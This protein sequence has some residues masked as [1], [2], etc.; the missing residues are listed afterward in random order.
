[1]RNN[2]WFWIALSCLISWAV[3]GFRMVHM[4]LACMRQG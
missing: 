3:M 4:V 2:K 1:M